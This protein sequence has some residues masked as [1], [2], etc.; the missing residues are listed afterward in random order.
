MPDPTIN[1]TPDITIPEFLVGEVQSKLAYIDEAIAG[2]IVES[3]GTKIV[4]MLKP[5]A[6]KPDPALITAK[7]QEVVRMMV[8]GVIKPRN[9]ILEDYL[10]RPVPS[11]SDPMN[12]LIS[13]PGSV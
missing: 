6:I 1:I 4:V 7:V 10:D 5:S 8:K 11:K 13:Q 3:D 12:E 9:Q 2:A